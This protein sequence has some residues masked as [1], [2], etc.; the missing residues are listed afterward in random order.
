LDFYQFWHLYCSVVSVTFGEKEDPMETLT[1]VALKSFFGW[2]TLINV[3]FLYFSAF[4]VILL[5]KHVKPIHMKMFALSDQ[6]IEKQYFMFLAYYK[7]LVI[8][9]FLVPYIALCVM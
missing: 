6:E 7:M 8:G 2:A 5:K 1:L 4:M 3:G 9:F